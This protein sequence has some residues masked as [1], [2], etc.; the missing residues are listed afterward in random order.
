MARNKN[1]PL[2]IYRDKRDVSKTPEPPGASRKKPRNAKK[3]ALRFV[4]QK[5]EATRL[6]YDF[7]LELDGVL[8]SWAV[9][10]GPSLDP[11]DKR[12]AVR[13][14]DHPLEYAEFEG[15]I[16]EGYG[17]GTVMIWDEGAWVPHEDP[18][19][20]LEAGALK[21][22]LK[23]KRLK[24]GWALIRMKPGPDEK[25]EN[26]LLVKER[27]A[28]ADEETDPLEKWTES[29]VS[30]C[31]LDEL[32]AK[33]DTDMDEEDEISIHGVR[34]THPDR[35][36]YEDQGATKRDIATYMAEMA[37]HLLPH[38]EQRPVSLVRCPSGASSQCFFQKH[39]TDS[40]PDVIGKTQIEE[41]DGNP[42]SYLLFD[43]SEALITAAQIGALELHIWAART[44]RLER[45]DRLVFDL[46]PD[47]G[48]SFDD[49]KASALEVRDRLEDAGLESFALLTGGKGIHVVAPLE[50]RQGWDDLKAAARGLARQMSQDAP[51]RYV[52]EA[53]KAKRRG[54]IF[55]DWLRNE[56]GATAICPF[57]LRARPGAPVATPVAWEELDGVGA[58]NAYTIGTIRQRLAQ[59]KRDPWEGYDSLRQSITQDVLGRLDRT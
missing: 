40:T 6:H 28:A 34:V 59:L 16:P 9:T 47:E 24:G 45:P 32:S 26:W 44:D 7:R 1:D 42:A 23:G 43:T 50:R 52:A 5:H 17:A 53:S 10:K 56:R 46:D 49:V 18:H 22:D 41:K 30:G 13:T 11:S 55:I 57:S 51:E 15:V 3:G 4:I 19:E 21:F 29:V 12:L 33:G 38:L 20:G 48:L 39:F 35:V 14:E 31:D 54:R 2:K 36:M 25:R 27:D 58:A 8:K 37:E